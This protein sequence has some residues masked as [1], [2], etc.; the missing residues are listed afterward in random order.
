[1]NVAD[2]TE[3]RNVVEEAIRLTQNLGYTKPY[4]VSIHV[5]VELEKKFR[6][7]R[8]KKVTP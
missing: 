1:M 6:L 8:R 4:D 3:A 2:H 7:V 5:I